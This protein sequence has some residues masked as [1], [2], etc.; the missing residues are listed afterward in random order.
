VLDTPADYRSLAAIYDALW[1]TDS[2]FDSR[3]V[4]RLQAS[5]PELIEMTGGMSTGEM[6][7]R[8]EALLAHESTS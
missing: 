5:R 1:P 2:A 6:V 7:K 4:Y 8:I 3:A